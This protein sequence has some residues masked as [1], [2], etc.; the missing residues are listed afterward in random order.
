MR[1]HLPQAGNT[2]TGH[3]GH[4]R[5]TWRRL[6]ACGPPLGNLEQIKDKCATTNGPGHVCTTWPKTRWSLG[7]ETGRGRTPGRERQKEF[8]RI[9]GW[10][11]PGFARAHEL[12]G[13]GQ[14]AV[15][16]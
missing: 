7:L 6:R 12:V 2:T 1:A 13:P 11:R 15:V 5:G 3:A 14:K 10:P 8:V 16:V 4:P 9:K